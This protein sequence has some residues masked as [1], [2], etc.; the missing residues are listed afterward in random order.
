M[1]APDLPPLPESV[2][3][4]R[5]DLLAAANR[6]AFCECG[7]CDLAAAQENHDTAIFTAL[8]AE[9]AQHADLLEYAWT[10]ICNA[11]GGDWTKESIEWQGAAARF[12]EQYHPPLAT[13]AETGQ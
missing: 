1:T 7:E 5:D 4:T 9:R 10:I 11:G 8:A 2:R 12:R 13:T 3:R 6:F